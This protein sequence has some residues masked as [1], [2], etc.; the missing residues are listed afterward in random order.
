MGPGPEDPD[1]EGH[2]EDGAQAERPRSGRI[3]ERRAPADLA[4]DPLATRARLRRA[5]RGDPALRCHPQRR[6]RGRAPGL[7]PR[8]R[9]RGGV[10]S[11]R[12]RDRRDPRRVRR[13]PGDRPCL[14][15]Q[16]DRDR[17]A[18]RGPCAREARPGP[19]RPRAAARNAGRG[20]RGRQGAHG[21]RGG[22]RRRRRGDDGPPLVGRPRDHAL[23]R[24]RGGRSRIPGRSGTRILDARS[25][26]ECARRAR[27][28]LSVD[29]RAAPAHPIDRTHPRHHHARRSRPRTSFP[30][31]R[32]VDSTFE[33]ETLPTSPRS[34][35]AYSAASRPAL[36]PREHRSRRASSIPTISS[37]KRTGRSPRR[38]RRTPR[39]S[40]A[41]SSRSSGFRRA[42]PEARTW[43][44]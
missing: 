18:R 35:S 19:S 44:T 23:H 10:R 16:P 13:A 28:R 40:V 7:R 42:S 32:P 8:D 11:C 14:R 2:G 38:T 24:G 1:G 26:R 43:E 27:D 3:D 5:P 21:A 9:V 31:T 29:R 22:L 4:G 41:A 17:G 36:A 33:R 34:R 15:P 12:S 20:A 6:P 37:S 25:R 30:T 39:R